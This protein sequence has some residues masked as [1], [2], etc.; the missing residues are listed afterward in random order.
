MEP[1]YKVYAKGDPLKNGIYQVLDSTHQCDPELAAG[2][3][4]I[5]EHPEKGKVYWDEDFQRTNPWKT[6]HVSVETLDSLYLR[7]L[8]DK[9]VRL[10]VRMKPLIVGFDVIYIAECLEYDVVLQADSVNKLKY[11]FCSSILDH[12]AYSDKIGEVPLENLPPSLAK[13]EEREYENFRRDFTYTGKSG[14][15][16]FEVN[17]KIA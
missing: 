9:F 1:E 6:G 7:R 14:R 17:F 3:I 13:L 11:L 8:A 10:N 12:C 4:E 2:Q 16:N 5:Y 15:I